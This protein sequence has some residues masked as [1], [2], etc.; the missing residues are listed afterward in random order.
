MKRS[1]SEMGYQNLEVGDFHS[2][3][4]RRVRDVKERKNNETKQIC[5]KEIL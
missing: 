5:Q 4:Y 3:L 2:E 1:T